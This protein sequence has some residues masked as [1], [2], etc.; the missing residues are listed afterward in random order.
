MSD[1]NPIP[2]NP[3]LALADLLHKT[4][5]A[6]IRQAVSSGLPLTDVP[7]LEQEFVHPLDA[8]RESPAL[9]P[10]DLAP[11]HASPARQ[12]R[13]LE[14]ENIFYVHVPAT[15]MISVDP[16]DGFVESEAEEVALARLNDLTLEV[17]LG[18]VPLEVITH[19]S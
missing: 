15:L 6:F 3:R 19:L 16:L 10:T 2:H 17:T 12:L 11:L 14:Q 18:G 1:T 5:D 4:A 7:A 13:V 9:L 8:I